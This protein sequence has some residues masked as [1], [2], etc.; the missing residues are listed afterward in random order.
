MREKSGWAYIIKLSLK[1]A[2]TY[3]EP[4]VCWA[5]AEHLGSNVV[6]ESAG[7]LDM[8]PTLRLK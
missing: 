5:Y 6:L 1:R 7:A 3:I 8:G 4:M 2:R